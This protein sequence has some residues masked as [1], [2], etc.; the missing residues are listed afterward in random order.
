MSRA[1]PLSFAPLPI[2]CSVATAPTPGFPSDLAAGVEDGIRSLALLEAVRRSI[3][4]N[5][6]VPVRTDA[7]CA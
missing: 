6:P 7:A 3:T 4:E 1:S 2:A 5:A